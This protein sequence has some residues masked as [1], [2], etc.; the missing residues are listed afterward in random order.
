MAKFR[1]HLAT[2]VDGTVVL[3]WSGSED[4]EPDRVESTIRAAAEQALSQPDVRRVEI[5]LPADDRWGRRAAL[6]AGFRVE[7]E[8]RAVL[9][10]PDGTFGDQTLF[11]RL[12]GD[13]VG[14]AHGFSAVMNSALPRKR[15]IAHV[16]MRDA[17]G[18]ILFCDTV[19][20][21]D[22][23]LPGGIV[24]PDEPPRRAAIREVREELGVELSV[25]RL[26]AVDWMPP[27]LGWDDACELIFDGGQV[28]EADLATFILQPSEIAAVQLVRLDAAVE[29]LTPLS[30]RRLAAIIASAPGETVLLEN[31]SPVMSESKSPDAKNP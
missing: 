28:S 23:E 7:G 24:E 30:A 20:K 25:G 1:T 3:S 12:A 29:H 18:R 16:L 15:M 27:Y 2:V 19:F 11:S 4:A 31:G 13:P 26:L 14:G 8:R 9:T 21:A 10:R 5:T 22:W 6:R 17:A